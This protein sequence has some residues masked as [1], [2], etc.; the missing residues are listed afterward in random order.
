MMAMM[1][2]DDPEEEVSVIY[3]FERS[4]EYGGRIVGFEISENENDEVLV[5]NTE[6][7]T[8]QDFLQSWKKD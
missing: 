4:S 2:A 1:M 6:I 3:L 8:Q 7:E 5:K